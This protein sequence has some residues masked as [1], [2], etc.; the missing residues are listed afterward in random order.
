MST[1]KS[2]DGF[3]FMLQSIMANFSDRIQKI[4]DLQKITQADLGKKA[5]R[6][7][8]TINRSLHSR[9]TPRFDTLKNIA[10]ALGV[11]VEVLTYADETIAI[12]IYELSRM[13]KNKTQQMLEQI[14]KDKF[15]NQRAGEHHAA[16]G[17]EAAR[18]AAKV[19]IAKDLYAEAILLGVN[20]PLEDYLEKKPRKKPKKAIQEQ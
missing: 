19:T 9:T 20:K 15:W 1:G 8:S 6:S 14:Q 13:P 11:P 3:P 12:I 7:Q 5:G 2:A 4:M 18:K 17:D 16:N 10:S